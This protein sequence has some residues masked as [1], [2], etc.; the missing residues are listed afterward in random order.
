MGLIIRDKMKQTAIGSSTVSG[1]V[2]PKKRSQIAEIMHRLAKNKLAMVGLAILALFIFLALFADVLYD[3]EGVVIKQDI[4]NMFAPPSKEHPCGTDELGRDILA[5]IVHGTRV[6]LAVGLVAVTFSM[7]IGVPLGAIAGFYGGRV[8]EVIMRG[9]DILN[10]LPSIMLALAIVT[11]F[12]QD[13]INMMIAVGISSIPSYIRIVRASVLTIKS[14][15]YVEAARAVGANDVHIIIKHVMINSLGPLIVE[16]SLRVASAI[17]SIASLSFLGLGIK[18]PTPE[19]GLMLSAGRD[20]LRDAPWL[21]I[22]PG[23]AIMLI[24]LALNLLGDG[25]R[26]ALDPKM[27]K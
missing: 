11:A 26:D 18:P 12:G 14:Q 4:L 8:G 2:L 9:A 22:F 16:A 23:I 10:A 24:V 3:Y 6:S 1:T 7:A 20:F 17:Q 27:K 5:R 19:W 15:E 21:T 13:M 25:L